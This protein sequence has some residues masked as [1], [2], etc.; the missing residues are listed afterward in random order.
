M[1][2]T[3]SLSRTILILTAA[4]CITHHNASAE[5]LQTSTGRTVIPPLLADPLEPKIAVMPS[6]SERT[7]QLDIGSS[8]DLYQS[9]SKDFA[10]GVDFGTYSRLKRTN[11]F[12]FP[13]DAIDY[14]FGVNASWKKPCN[15][16][17]LPFDTFSAKVK[18][19]HISA[20]FEDGH[21]SA[22]QW[23]TQPEWRETIPFTYSREFVN[24][25]LALSSPEHRLYAGYQ[26]LYHTLPSGIN[27]HA[28]QAGFEL[29]TPGNSYIAT[30]FKLLPIWQPS[31]E[32]T[33]G[34]RGTWNLQAGIRL[35]NIGLEKVRVACNYYSGI[36][37]QG[38][39][40][41]HPES[42]TSAGV[43]IDF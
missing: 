27:P 29:S 34:H 5:P 2:R 14:L 10:I 17:M 8:T 1:T 32:A 23:I 16:D 30:D 35:N 15:S 40:F 36:S 28:F 19:S 21:Y 3:C 42:F 20:H 6:L 31:L 25:V 22:G 11:E 43:I 13:V 18:I 37:R 38:M 26:Y 33:R 9:E 39:Y 12:K 4:L 41:Y 7:L 24:L